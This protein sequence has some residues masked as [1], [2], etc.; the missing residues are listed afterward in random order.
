MLLDSVCYNF[1]DDFCIYL[2]FI[3]VI[4][5]I[6]FFFF[7]C[8]FFVWFQYQ[9]DGGLVE[10]VCVF[11]LK[12]FERVWK[13]GIKVIW[14][15]A[16]VFLGEIFFYHSFNFSGCDWFVIISISFWINLGRLNFSKSLSIFSKLSTLLAYT[17]LQQS[18]MILCISVLSVPTSPFSFLN[19][20]ESSPFFLYEY[21]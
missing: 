7:F 20:L 21:G 5:V 8:N 19:L 1:V 17:C 2:M 13:T 14:P 10:W 11:P 18:L 4:D 15:W 9:G 3:I 6:F 12:F 16:F